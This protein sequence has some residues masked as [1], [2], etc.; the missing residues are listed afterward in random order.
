[1]PVRITTNGLFRNYRSNLYTS[2]NKLNDSMAQVQ[3]QRN[4]NAYADDPAAASRAFQ[5]RRDFWRAGDQLDNTNYVISKFSTAF[6]ALDGIIEGNEVD[7]GGLNGIADSLRGLNDTNAG[8]RKALGQS[9]VTS[10]ESIVRMMNVQY[11]DDFVFAAAD[12]LNVPFSWGEDGQLLYRGVDVSMEKPKT[13]AELGVDEALLDMDPALSEEEFEELSD[14]DDLEG[15]DDVEDF[16]SYWDANS[17]HYTLYD[18]ELGVIT[19]KY[20][21]YKDWYLAKNTQYSTFAEAEKDYAQVQKYNE[22]AEE[23]QERNGVD[24]AQGAKDY[25]KLQAMVEEA[26]YVDIGIGMQLNE[27]RD[28]IPTSA[29][30]S[31]LSGLTFLGYSR[32]K[33]GDSQNIAVLMNELGQIFNR[34]DRETGAYASPEDEERASI[35]TGKVRDGISYMIEQH[36]KLSASVTYLKTNVEQ[37]TLS[38]DQLDEQIMDVEQI[39]PAMAISAMS[40][41]QYCYNA[42]LRIGTNILSQSLIDYM[43]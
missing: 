30:N 13:A 18:A 35:L 34:C 24:V 41:A 25:A 26:T 37:L 28:V 3:T 2:K 19:E 7:G 4:F 21:A 31:A 33:D 36:T 12:G 17:S 29:F 40:W 14:Y 42:A 43:S 22:Y 39:D 15:N 5:L 10:S 8:A 27:N 6:T 38:R 23:Y 9:L 32:D 16:E 11:G 1:M 20:L